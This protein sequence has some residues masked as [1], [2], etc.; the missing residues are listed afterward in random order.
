M[1]N[2]PIPV[3]TTKFHSSFDVQNQKFDQLHVTNMDNEN[4]S[5][6][7]ISHSLHFLKNTF[8]T[9]KTKRLRIVSKFKISVV[10]V[11]FSYVFIVV[12]NFL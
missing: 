5:W 12:Y 4:F 2:F 3:N 1:E 9:L 11:K 10:T 7:K 8:I 6:I